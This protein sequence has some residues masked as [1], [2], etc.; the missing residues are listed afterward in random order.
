MLEKLKKINSEILPHHLIPVPLQFVHCCKQNSLGTDKTLCTHILW[1]GME[2]L[3][4]MS[5]TQVSGFS[6]V[7]AAARVEV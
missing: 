1:N 7:Q 3:I 4:H 2:F 5:S 6:L